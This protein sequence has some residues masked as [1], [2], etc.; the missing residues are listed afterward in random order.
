M[1]AALPADA[2]LPTGAG[3][4]ANPV[5]KLTEQQY[6]EIERAAEFK[7]EF[8]DGEMIAMSG[9]TLRHSDIASNVLAEL[10]GRL[11]GSQCKA[12]NADLRVRASERLCS[13]PDVS[14]ICGKPALAGENQDI[15]LNPIVI[16]EVLS[17]TTEKYDRGLKFQLYRT[18]ESLREYILVS[19][20]SVRVEHYVR[21]DAT[22][23]T[24]RDYVSMNDELKMDS[25]GASLPLHR[26]YDGVELEPLSAPDHPTGK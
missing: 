10:R 22:T 11:R 17:P 9:A 15:L 12:F 23:W 13:Y 5:T 24:L 7:H 20:G 21:Q 2:K 18:N 26:I 25:I 6:L 8:L 4:A 14:V 3:M 1:L 16:F 19:Q